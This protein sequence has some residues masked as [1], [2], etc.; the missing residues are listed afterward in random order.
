MIIAGTVIGFLVGIIESVAFQN[1]AI[2]LISFLG[3]VSGLY[4]GSIG[5]KIEE[6]EN[7]PS[8]FTEFK[9]IT[10]RLDR[11]EKIE[12]PDRGTLPEEANA[13]KVELAELEATYARMKSYLGKDG[14][15]VFSA[16]I[17]E[18]RQKAESDSAKL[19]LEV[20]MR[21]ERPQE[22]TEADSVK[23]ELARLEADYAQIKP[24]LSK[25]GE[26]FY[27]AKLR[28]ARQKAE[29]SSV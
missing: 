14:E 23:A 5:P 1:I 24:Y 27:S 17:R 7:P 6:I 2:A 8:Y 9:S 20:K 4:L 19:D 21:S 10:D 28:E 26:A 18:A 25:Q 13:A 29:S 3:L 22:P 15:E 11:L 16:R 12:R